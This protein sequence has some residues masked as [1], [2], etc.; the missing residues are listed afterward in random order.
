MP[1]PYRSALRLTRD[2]AAPLAAET[3]PLAAAVGR[4]TAAPVLSAELSPNA[5]LAALD[6]FAVRA[7][8]LRGAS[9][10]S[11]CRLAVR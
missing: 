6:G 3:V 10:A 11:P 9:A 2:A 8:E 1:L 4:V 7:A 5:D